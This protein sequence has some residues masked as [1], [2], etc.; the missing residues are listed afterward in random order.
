MSWTSS[1]TRAFS[2]ARDGRDPAHFAMQLEVLH[3]LTEDLELPDHGAL[4]LA[5]RQEAATAG[6][7]L[8]FDLGDRALNVIQEQTV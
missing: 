3:G 6:S 5:V 4:R 2:S 8:A 1:P 7:R